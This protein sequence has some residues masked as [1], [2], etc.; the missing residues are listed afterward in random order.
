MPRASSE[1]LLR[2]YSSTNLDNWELIEEKN[3][4]VQ[5]DTLFMKS[6]IVPID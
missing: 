5:E 2:T 6:E 3:V 4:D 1:V